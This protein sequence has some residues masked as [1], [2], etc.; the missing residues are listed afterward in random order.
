MAEGH[1]P[2]NA[3]SLPH[4]GYQ[5]VSPGYFAAIGIPLVRG[6]D[7]SRSDSR[8]SESVVVIS[9]SL[10]RQGWPREEA[11]GKRLRLGEKGPWLRVV[12]I[13][14]DIRHL[15]PT[16]PVQPELYQPDSQRS[17]P[18]MAFVVRTDVDPYSVVPSLRNAVATLDPAMPLAGLKTMDE[19]MSR[20]LA[21]PKFLSGLVTAFGALAVALALLGVYAMMAW[22]VSE[23]RQEIAVRMALGARPSKILLA[24]AVRALALSAV[25]LGAGLA[26][27]RAS[28]GVLRGL[29]YGIGPDDPVAYAVTAGAIVLVILGACYLPARRA[30]RVD[31]V[32]A[33]R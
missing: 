17:F 25:G 16:Q 26:A 6:R 12:G 28:G 15:G 10:A 27:A 21:K 5:V 13:V 2:V 32:A 19:H 30:L 14:G 24:V 22:S 7:V 31:P 23:R 11:V 8:A 9:E 29:L 33:L 1:Q 20:A 4:A 3:A 18:F